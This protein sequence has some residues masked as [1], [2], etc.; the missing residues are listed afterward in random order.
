MPGPRHPLGSD[1]QHE[2]KRAAVWCSAGQWQELLRNWLEVQFRCDVD[3]LMN[4]PVDRASG[5]INGNHSLRRHA[6]RLRA[7]VGRNV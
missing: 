3:R 5:S 1:K 7:T 6:L 4:G 2:L